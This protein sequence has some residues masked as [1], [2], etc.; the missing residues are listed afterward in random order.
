MVVW[1]L[2]CWA[3]CG[4]G[5]STFVRTRRTR[6]TTAAVTHRTVSPTAVTYVTPDP[7]ALMTCERAHAWTHGRVR[8]CRSH[9]T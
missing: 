2:A 4:L 6:E 1:M 8:C 5:C 9:C 3:C 7:P